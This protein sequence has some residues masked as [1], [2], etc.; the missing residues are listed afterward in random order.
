MVVAGV[1][2]WS[3]V[4]RF[5][6]GRHPI[7]SLPQR[8]G[9]TLRPTMRAMLFLFLAGCS[10]SATPTTT[11]PTT[12]PVETPPVPGVPATPPADPPRTADAKPD[13]GT[14]DPALATKATAFI[15]AFT[16]YSPDFT[17][18]GKRVVFASN[19]DG[20]PQ[21]YIADPAKPAEAP[22]RVLTTKERAGGFQV[23]NDGKTLLFQSDVGADENWSIYRVGLDGQ[24]LADLTP[25]ERINRDGPVVPDKKQDTMFFSARKMSE[26]KSTLYSASVTTP[27]PAKAI[28]TD[29][30]PMFLYST[31]ATGTHALVT[32]YPS[33]DENH[34]LVVDL[35][36][37]KAEKIFPESGKVTVFGLEYSPDGKTI[38]VATDNGTEQSTLV[39]LDAKTKKVRAKHDFKPS[40]AGVSQPLVSKKTGNIAVNL[41]VG[42]YS[43]IRILDGKT[44]KQKSAVK[45][46]LGQGAAI[47]WSDDGKRLAVHWSTPSAP[48]TLFTIDA[49]SGTSTAIRTEP[50]PTLKGMPEIAA[51]VVEIPAFDG[52]KI[53]ANVYVA[54]G[55]EAKPHPTLVIY[56][57]GPS[58]VSMVR[59]SA[60]TAFFVSLGYAVV[61]PNVRGSSGYGRAFEA[62]DNG[63]K[64]LDA[65]KDIETSSRWVAKQPWADK[66]RL[67]VYGGSYGGYTTLIALSRWPDI[68]RAGVNL[69]G[70]VDLKT[71][72][73]TTS[74][75]IRKIFL[76][77]FGDPDRDAEF[78]TQI[79]PI[80]D[81]DKIVDPTFVYAGANDPRVPR[82]E[83]D[84]IVKALRTRKV[85]SEYMV[86][87]NEGH[88]LAHRAN[89]IE[90][91]ARCA[92]FLAAALK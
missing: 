53:P 22:T 41:T 45:M 85:A 90:F 50:R 48:T 54:K 84:I 27:G 46:P 8:C 33:R 16:E 74:G 52:G 60:A 82:S 28:Y 64:R 78:L 47:D 89:Q 38:Y 36:S 14:V 62:G 23:L 5:D 29:E 59:W 39:A 49:A 70:V 15:D 11:T 25:G 65:F 9:C 63:P 61:E 87:D 51:S 40:T 10:G 80:T 91:Y 26:Q 31:N 19:R 7:R 44:L 21:I 55:E 35:A 66:D 30:L 76:V 92:R 1:A 58:G 43:E 88:S 6:M 20:L 2:A 37:G 18:D 81:V 75:L 42:S 71:F 57:G 24:G 83:S 72:M 73:Q 68:Y 32:Q 13:A 79:S 3:L 4:L 12:D 77:E 69:F 86:S 17:P 67:V 56:H 34:V